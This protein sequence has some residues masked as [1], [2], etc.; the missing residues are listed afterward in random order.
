MSITYLGDSEDEEADRSSRLSTTPSDSAR[1]RSMLLVPNRAR[2]GGDARAT[3]VLV[4]GRI[5]ALLCNKR[6][7]NMAVIFIDARSILYVNGRNSFNLESDF[8][9]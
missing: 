3:N 6:S 1:S 2:F 7:M 8:F 5:P 9:W 4:G